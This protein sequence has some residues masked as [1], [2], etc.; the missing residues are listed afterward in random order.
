MGSA[1]I[2]CMHSLPVHVGLEDLPTSSQRGLWSHVRLCIHVF[3]PLIKF[4]WACCHPNSLLKFDT[5]ALLCKQDF[6]L[7]HTQCSPL[8][9]AEVY[10]QVKSLACG[11]KKKHLWCCLWMSAS[12][13][14]V[15]YILSDEQEKTCLSAH[16]LIP[17]I[18]LIHAEK[19]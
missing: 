13:C 15:K 14:G 1:C 3:T 9:A 18:F 12:Y 11:Y 5:S 17:L 19:R 10:P 2:G 16:F 7:P 4:L 8:V 6:S